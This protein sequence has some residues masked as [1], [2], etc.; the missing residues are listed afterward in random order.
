MS[1][2]CECACEELSGVCVWRLSELEELLLGLP[3]GKGVASCS[4]ED[5]LQEA[6][7]QGSK[8]A[9][10]PCLPTQLPSCPRVKIFV[11]RASSHLIS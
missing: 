11:P 8:Q 3:Q 5:W 10:K 4:S 1:L 6:G 9:K 2:L 7:R